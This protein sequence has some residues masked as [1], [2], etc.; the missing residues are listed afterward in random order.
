MLIILII[1]IYSFGDL[2]DV[3]EALIYVVCGLL[4]I[5]SL[6]IIYDSYMKLKKKKNSMVKKIF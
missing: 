1:A 4:I 2:D 5:I 3:N 6:D